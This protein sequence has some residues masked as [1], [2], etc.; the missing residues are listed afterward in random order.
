MTSWT[1]AATVNGHSTVGLAYDRFTLTNGYSDIIDHADGE[2]PD[3]LKA[4]LHF[5]FKAPGGILRILDKCS[6][7]QTW[8]RIF[9][10]FELQLQNEAALNVK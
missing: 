6:H 7:S 1:T 10:S 9:D 2:R 8:E 5:R 4:S 3:V